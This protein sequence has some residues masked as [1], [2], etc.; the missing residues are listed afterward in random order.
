M[1]V[2]ECYK[3]GVN[4]VSIYLKQ[5]DK[6]KQIIPIWK[7]K[8]ASRHSNYTLEVRSVRT[9]DRDFLYEK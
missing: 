3:F 4:I 6:S 1:Q 9:L 8:I 7:I 5:D 2:L